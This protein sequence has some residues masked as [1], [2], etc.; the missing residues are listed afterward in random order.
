MIGIYPF[1]Q[2]FH[3]LLVKFSFLWKIKTKKIIL[4]ILK[5]TY[6]LQKVANGAKMNIFDSNIVCK[7][8]FV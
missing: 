8:I 5:L 4:F 3:I 1:F 7:L 2:S 6:S